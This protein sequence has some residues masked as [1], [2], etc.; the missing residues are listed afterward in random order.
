MLIALS[1]FHDELCTVVLRRRLPDRRN[2]ELCVELSKF[3]FAVKSR[4]EAYSGDLSEDAPN[5]NTESFEEA[6]FLLVSREL[7]YGKLEE[8]RPKHVVWGP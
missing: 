3:C 5:G 7:L 2:H 1:L 6:R 4:Q 8:H